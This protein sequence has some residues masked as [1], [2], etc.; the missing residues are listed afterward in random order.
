MLK[1]PLQGVHK[2]HDAMPSATNLLFK[3]VVSACQLYKVKAGCE[4]GCPLN[5]ISLGAALQADQ[6]E[7]QHLKLII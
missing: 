3:R 1:T 7:G 5:I 2:H 4:V 6:L